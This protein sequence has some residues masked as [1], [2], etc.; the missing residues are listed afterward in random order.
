MDKGLKSKYFQDNFMKVGESSTNIS[1]NKGS[2]W[3]EITILHFYSKV[4]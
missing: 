2:I 1:I 4:R 3:K